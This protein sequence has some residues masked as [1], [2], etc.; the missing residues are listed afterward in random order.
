MS[1][2]QSSP[3]NLK[4]QSKYLT[5]QTALG[6]VSTLSVTPEQL[7]DMKEKVRAIIQS[8]KTAFLDSQTVR[9]S[10]LEK[11]LRRFGHY[12]GKPVSVKLDYEPD[13]T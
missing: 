6:K 5:D 10:K 1:L 7:A 11:P 9:N 12:P 3:L 8:K 4:P 2:L 13:P